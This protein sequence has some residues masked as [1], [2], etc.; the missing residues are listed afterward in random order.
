MINETAE[1]PLLK[2]GSVRSA[3]GVFEVNP[4]TGR[5]EISV[6]YAILL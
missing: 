1:G 3:Q 6:V 2:I 5:R 4:S